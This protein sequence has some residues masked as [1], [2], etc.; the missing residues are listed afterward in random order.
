LPAQSGSSRSMWCH[1]ASYQFVPQGPNFG[2]GIRPG[3]DF[4]T[5]IASGCYALNG[6]A[7]F[8]SGGGGGA[9]TSGGGYCW[10][11]H[12]AG[13]LVIVTFR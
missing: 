5:S 6:F 7:S 4:C 1:S 12:G 8:P 10:G 13:G 3:R 9:M 11:G 2:G